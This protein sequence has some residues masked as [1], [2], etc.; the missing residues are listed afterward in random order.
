MATEGR[1]FERVIAA[2]GN[3]GRDTLLAVRFLT[4]LPLPGKDRR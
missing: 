1:T 3:W 2:A 4:R